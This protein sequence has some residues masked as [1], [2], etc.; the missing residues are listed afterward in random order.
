VD[1]DADKDSI[2][3]IWYPRGYDMDTICYLISADMP[4]SSPMFVGAQLGL[5]SVE[6]S[7]N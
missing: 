5:A 1:L 6:I 7:G 3:G 4:Q 2:L